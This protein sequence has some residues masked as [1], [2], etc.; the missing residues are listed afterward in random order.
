MD[1]VQD[2]RINCSRC[3]GFF[4][5]MQIFKHHSVEK[6]QPTMENVCGT[7]WLK[8]NTPE[9][10]LRNKLSA[11]YLIYKYSWGLGGFAH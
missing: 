4:P 11:E 10:L 7:C 8:L 9:L 2:E 6:G 5:V 1:R 3:T